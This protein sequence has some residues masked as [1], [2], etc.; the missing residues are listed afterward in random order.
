MTNDRGGARLACSRL[1]ESL[2]R[3]QKTVQS[4]RSRGSDAQSQFDEW[5]S[6]WE[7]GREQIVQRLSLI[8][9]HLEELVQERD[10]RPQ[11]SLH[12]DESVCAS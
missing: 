11:L 10:R 2:T 6:R 5:L 12:R 1:S 8:D 3:L 9:S 7:S 4:A